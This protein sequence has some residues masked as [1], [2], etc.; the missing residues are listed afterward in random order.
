VGG[1]VIGAAANPQVGSNRGGDGVGRFF[2][3]MMTAVDDAVVDGDALCCSRF[4]PGVVDFSRWKSTTPG[5]K[6]SRCGL[7]LS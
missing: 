4:P 7:R 3:L 2:G 6:A 5:G 1:F